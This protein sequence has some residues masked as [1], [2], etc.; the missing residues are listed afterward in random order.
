LANAIGSFD[1]SS[2][3]SGGKAIG[4]D[5]MG[6]RSYMVGERGPELF[7]PMGNGSI[8]PNSGGATINQ[9]ISIDA[10]GADAGVEQ[11][12]MQA[13]RQTKAETLAE[14]QAKANRGG[15]FARAVGRA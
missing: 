5:V 7:T 3:F 8:T 4:G 9:T 2:I 14:V 13:M 11:R 15:S 1:F 10:R 12:I 6:G